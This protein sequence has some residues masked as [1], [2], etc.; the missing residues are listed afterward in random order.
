MRTHL[1]LRCKAS[2]C[3]VG[4][5]GTPSPQGLGGSQEALL[6]ASLGLAPLGGR[7]AQA[8]ALDYSRMLTVTMHHD[9]RPQSLLQEIGTEPLKSVSSPVNG[10]TAQEDGETGPRQGRAPVPSL[11]Q[12]FLTA[13][14][15]ASQRITPRL[16]FG[17]VSTGWAR[18]VAKSKSY[19]IFWVSEFMQLG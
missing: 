17:R 13:L 5:C 2:C 4:H 11:G 9:P 10:K 3:F 15:P 7:P 6:H 14:S 19:K 18:C 8:A 1:L 16:C 12:H